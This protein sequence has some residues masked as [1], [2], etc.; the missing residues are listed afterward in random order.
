MK[1]LQNKTILRSQGWLHR[2]AIT[3]HISL[4][5]SEGFCFEGAGGYEMI[6]VAQENIYLAKSSRFWVQLPYC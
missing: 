1:K 5:R 2:K 3:G 4:E 6:P